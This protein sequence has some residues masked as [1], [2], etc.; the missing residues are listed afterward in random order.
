M[1]NAQLSGRESWEMSPST[2]PDAATT[3]NRHYR[4]SAARV[5][6]LDQ[7]CIVR[8]GNIIVVPTAPP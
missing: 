8:S 2:A 1:T 4:G 7:P 5:K 3:E 6:V